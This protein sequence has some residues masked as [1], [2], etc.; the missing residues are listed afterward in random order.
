MCAAPHGSPAIKV[1][2]D[3]EKGH[4]RVAIDMQDLKDLKSRLFQKRFRH[5][6][7]IIPQSL[8]F[9]ES[10]FRHLEACL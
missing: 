6:D 2:T 8:E 1:L 3:L 4:T 9:C 10:C 7:E 5:R